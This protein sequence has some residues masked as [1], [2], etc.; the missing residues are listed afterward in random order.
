MGLV[1]IPLGPTPVGMTL[2][3]VKRHKESGELYFDLTLR[4]SDGTEE[5]LQ[6]VSYEKIVGDWLDWLPAQD[7][8]DFF[9]ACARALAEIKKR[10]GR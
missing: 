4:K 1:P 5:R 2:H 6:D 7:S 9:A 8:F 3:S 10:Q